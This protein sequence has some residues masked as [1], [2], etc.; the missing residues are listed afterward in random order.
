[1]IDEFA[2]VVT[3]KIRAD[4]NNL[5]DELANGRAKT[6]EDYRHACGVIRGL[7]IA[8]EYIQDLAKTAEEAD[9]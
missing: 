3:K 4:M 2:K 7:A 5:A 1:M 8:E 9:E 6:I